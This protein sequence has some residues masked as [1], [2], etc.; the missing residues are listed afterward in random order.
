MDEGWTRLVLDSFHFPYTVLHNADI[1]KNNLKENL[2]V[3]L[4]PSQSSNT[5]LHGRRPRNNFLGN[6][7]TPA[8]YQGGIGRRGTEALLRFV[9]QGGTLITLDRACEFAIQELGI[10]ASNP[11][12]ELDRKEFYVPGSLL[13][14]ELDP[15]SPLTYGMPARTAVRLSRSMAF[16]LYPYHREVQVAGYYGDDD[17]LLSG[18]LRGG[19]KLAGKAALAEFPV[20]RG[21]VI[22][23][24]F[25][26]QSRAQTHGTF[27]L[28]FNAIYTSRIEPVENLKSQLKP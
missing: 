7:L 24:G 9:R 3:I 4:L 6:P 19:E 1:Q 13:A 25:G 12:A 15:A 14:M 16:R 28:L 11:L 5:L 20:G 18:W 10:P 21:R 26:V 22:L 8:A 17:P 23:F 2:D 27:K